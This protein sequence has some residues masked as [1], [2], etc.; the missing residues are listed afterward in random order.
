MKTPF[1]ARA[2]III[3]GIM[4]GLGLQ[5]AL[6]DEP[7]L[8]VMSEDADDDA[9][10]RKSRV[11]RRVITAIQNQMVDQGFAVYDETMVTMDDFKQDK[12]RRTRA[13]ILD[14]AR[15][16]SNPPIDIVTN[17]LIY[18]SVNEV[19]Y[20]A[21]VIVRIEGE[22]L[23][24]KSKKYLGNFESV[25]TREWDISP[26]CAKSRECVLEEVGEKSRIIGNDVGSVLAEKLA[27][28]VKGDASKDGYLSSG[29]QLETAYEIVLDGFSPEEV[30]AMEEYLIKFTGYQ[31]HRQTYNSNR[32]A[33]MWYEGTTT[34][35]RMNRNMNKMLAVLDLRGTVQFSGNKIVVQKISLRGKEKSVPD[36]VW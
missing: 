9:V 20:T 31:S 10:P 13:E 35:S 25:S 30:M 27:Y 18:A 23:H 4:L 36:D 28:M 26:K 22:I 33:E 16:V 17:F 24:V 14:I 6:A 7:N 5:P 32:R 2:F 8:F 3:F 34:S 21:K 11:F 19:G 29:N 1:T 15:T 12:S